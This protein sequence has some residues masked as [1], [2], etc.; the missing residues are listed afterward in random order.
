ML[1]S[2]LAAAVPAAISYFGTKQTNSANRQMANNQMAFQQYNSDT[3]YQRS[4]ADMRK[5]GLNPI[6]AYKQGGASTPGG[7]SAT[8][9]DPLSAGVN[10]AMSA[11]RL[12][13]DYQN[14]SA[15]TDLVKQNKANAVATGKGIDIANQSSAAAMI[16]QNKEK[17]VVYDW[18]T[19]QP[20][21]RDFGK[22]SIQD[23]A[24][25]TKY[26]T[27]SISSGAN[28]AASLLRLFK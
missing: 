25:I 18:L 2:L 13:A 19:R 9:Q 27:G 3:A 28:S 7:A 10:S 21:Y 8:M 22:M 11:V 17:Q 23:Q 16:V 24:I 6:L 5:A 1:G 20:G 4:M 12:K 15:N 26:L 14:L